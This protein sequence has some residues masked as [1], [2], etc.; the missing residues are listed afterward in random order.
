MAKN[1]K[2]DVLETEFILHEKAFWQHCR[3]CGC[4]YLEPISW[5]KKGDFVTKCPKCKTELF[6]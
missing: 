3:Q 4:E 5:I 6:I 1:K 2:V